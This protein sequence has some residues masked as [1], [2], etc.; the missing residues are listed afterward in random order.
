[1]KRLRS[2]FI[3]GILVL[4]PLVITL[5]LLWLI[6]SFFNRVL[7]RL[8]GGLI[9]AIFGINIPGLGLV[10]TMALIFLAGLFATNV[11]GKRFI[12]LGDNI[13]KRIPLVSSVYSGVKQIMEAIFTQN[14]SSFKQVVMVEYPREGIYTL[15]FVTG[16][17]VGEVQDKTIDKVI[18]LFVPTTPNPTSGFFLMVPEKDVVPLEM[19]VQEGL[20]MIISGGMITPDEKKAPG[21]E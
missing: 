16:E 8:I 2:Y 11:L 13:I 19:S 1:M 21:S 9:F 20:K 3:T 14:R 10:S 7:G 18:N 4:S 12:E 15:A 5:Y 6:Y 17:G